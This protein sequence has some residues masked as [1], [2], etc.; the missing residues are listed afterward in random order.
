MA[1]RDIAQALEKEYQRF[2]WLTLGLMLL[3]LIGQASLYVL[4]FNVLSPRPLTEWLIP[5]AITTLVLIVVTV[6]IAALHDHNRKKIIEETQTFFDE[7]LA[8]L[9]A[10]DNRG[11]QLQRMA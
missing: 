11:T 2:N 1:K 9:R 7:E 6:A 3:A 8:E 4:I 5:L 10:A